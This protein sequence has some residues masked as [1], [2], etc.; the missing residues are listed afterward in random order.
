MLDRRIRSHNDAFYPADLEALKAAHD[1]LC[2]GFNVLPDTDDA[3]W[4]AAELIRLFQTGMANED[5][6][7]I[8]VRARWQNDWKATG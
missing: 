8:A 3:R 4:I 7:V 2:G 6:L 5:M 1:T